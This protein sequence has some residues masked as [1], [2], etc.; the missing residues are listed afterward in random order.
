MNNEQLKM[1]NQISYISDW[2]IV[3]IWFHFQ[4][5]MSKSNYVKFNFIQK[6]CFLKVAK[7]NKNYVL[8]HFF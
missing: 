4:R 1:N 5:E 6:N 3:F 8:I 7:K 2:E